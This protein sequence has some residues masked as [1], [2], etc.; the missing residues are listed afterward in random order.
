MTDARNHYRRT[1]KACNLA[2]FIQSA[3]MNLSPFLFV[4][5][6]LLYG[7]SYTQVGL[8]VL[9]NFAAQFAADLHSSAGKTTD[10]SGTL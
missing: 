10:I 8:L 4:P 2:G 5:L 3:T 7:L 9:L 1:L 6:M